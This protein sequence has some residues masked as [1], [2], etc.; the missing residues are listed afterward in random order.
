MSKLYGKECGLTYTLSFSTKL[1]VFRV[2]SKLNKQKVNPTGHTREH[3]IRSVEPHAMVPLKCIAVSNKSKLFLVGKQYISTHNSRVSADFLGTR[4]LHG[5]GRLYWLVAADYN[6]TRAEFDY[7]C[8]ILDKLGLGY[9]ATKQVDPG[10]IDI[11]GGFRVMTKSAQDPRKLAMEAPDGVVVCEA[12]QV[13]YETYLR[14]RGRI[15]EKRGWMLLS[16]TFESSLGWYPE[17]Y[18]RG[19][20]AINDPDAI[21]S[22]SL[23][24][25][26][27]LAI[28]PG[29]EQDPEIIRLKRDTPADYFLERYGGIPCPP[30]GRVFEEFSMKIHVGSDKRY[31]FEKDKQTYL[32]VDPGYAEAYAV[33]VVQK[34]GDHLWI[35]DEVYER[36][37]TT[38]EIITKCKQRAWWNSITGGAIDVAATQH[39]AM[40]AVS[41]IWASEGGISLVSNKV[42][43]K[44]GIEQIKRFLLVDPKSNESMLH[45]HPRC[46][47]I[48]SEFGGCPNPID[49]QT[50]VYTWKQ[51]KNNMTIGDTPDD[52][53]NHGIKALAYGIVHL[54][55]YTKRS[56]R[57][58]VRFF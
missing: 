48:I 46:K 22:F 28:F 31:D 14:L 58:K 53:H 2:K 35:V 55:G 4:F 36:G 12:S 6:R 1:P 3:Y 15:A 29:G 21:K 30:K 5:R 49:G 19:Q 33:E 47:G 37:L 9:T 18:V 50:K 11:A 26:S 17:L 45:I 57:A 38:S 13:D 42:A 25:W 44:D 39:Q 27:N 16:G 40:P 41:E 34:K 7:F 24:T 10:E 54:F 56:N 43:I 52:K 32:F 51:D 8:Q 23:P 20:A